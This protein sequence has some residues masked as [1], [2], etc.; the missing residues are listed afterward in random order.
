MPD[1]F[2]GCAPPRLRADFL[3]IFL[4]VQFILCRDIQPVA[5]KVCIILK[6]EM[7]LKE[8]MKPLIL[9][10]PETQV[11]AR[12]RPEDQLLAQQHM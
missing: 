3:S 11:D 12:N 7:H 5:L 4:L 10:A 2:Q 1:Y 9:V 8:N 6:P